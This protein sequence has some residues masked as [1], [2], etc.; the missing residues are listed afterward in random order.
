MTFERPETGAGTGV[1][2]NRQG[3][4]LGGGHLL[5]PERG[6]GVSQRALDDLQSGCRNW[7]LAG[8]FVSKLKPERQAKLHFVMI[9]L[10]AEAYKPLIWPASRSNGTINGVSYSSAITETTASHKPLNNIG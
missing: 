6:V 2:S 10:Q 1:N 3:P 4:E 8:M 7:R 5:Q 9:L